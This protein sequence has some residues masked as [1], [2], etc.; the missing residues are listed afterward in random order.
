MGGGVTYN[1]NTDSVS[2]TTLNGAWDCT[3]NIYVSAGGGSPSKIT[4]ALKRIN[5]SGVVQETI[6]QEQK[7]VPKDTTS[8]VDCTGDASKSVTFAAGD[9]VMFT[10]WET[11]GTRTIRINYNGADTDDSE[12][13]IP[14]TGPTPT[15]S[16]TV[17]PTTS[18]SPTISPTISP[19]NTPAGTPTATPAWKIMLITHHDEVSP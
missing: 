11:G 12:V 7:T 16:P 3:L 1:W 5:S 13:V 17:S 18:P 19:T 6:F 4:Y 9:G 8:D 2:G 14:A 10:I 15:V